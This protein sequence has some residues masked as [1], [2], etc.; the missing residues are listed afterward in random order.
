MLEV[1]NNICIIVSC[2]QFL[3]DI[4]LFDQNLQNSVQFSLVEINY[5]LSNNK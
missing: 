1:S 4:N 5:D 3:G 2:I